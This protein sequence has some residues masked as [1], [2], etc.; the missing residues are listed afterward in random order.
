MFGRMMRETGAAVLFFR[1]FV[2]LHHR[3]H[4]AVEDDDALAEKV[5]E[6]VAGSGVHGEG[7]T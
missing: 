2:A 4:G 6:R 7:A 1:E 3:A 5:L